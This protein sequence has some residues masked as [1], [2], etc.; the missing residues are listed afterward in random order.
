MPSHDLQQMALP[1]TPAVSDGP[2]RVPLTFGVW[3]AGII[4]RWPLV[5]KV[6]G[7]VLVLAA[8]G[9]VVIPPAYRAHASFVT[10]ISSSGKLTGG[11]GGASAMAG[12][13]TQFGLGATGDPS[14][15]PNFYVKLIESDELRRRLVH[16]RFA[17]PRTD[18]PRDSASL[19]EILKIKNSNSRR[20]EEIAI[21]Q[22]SKSVL[23]SFDAK[24]NLVA[25]TVN[26]RWSELAAA[27]ANRTIGLVDGFN[28]E[29]RVSR[30][31]SKRAFLEQRLNSSNAD[32][33][34]AEER[35]RSFYQQNRLWRNSP[36]LVFEEGRIQRSVDVAQSL[37][38]TLQQQFEA[39]RLD[40]FNDAALI[41]IVDPAVPPQ[42]AQWPRYWLLL[43]SSLVLG[44]I[45]GVLAA[46]SATILSDWS[47][48]NPATA[49]EL[50]DSLAAIPRVRRGARIVH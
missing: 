19:I 28:R 25:L 34:A 40:E 9:S 1:L 11:M 32:L 30:A 3:I 13:A 27:M 50:S 4:R 6:M 17:D 41:T 8:I 43:A 49:S 16:S 47:A 12:L 33:R 23:A 36:H 38:L 37:Y 45:L 26:S 42:K 35:L 15:S 20:R 21:K 22:V 2:E 48:R 14:E 44:A 39:A 18:N 24:T 29:Q 7:V 5:L 46:G 10:N 31:R